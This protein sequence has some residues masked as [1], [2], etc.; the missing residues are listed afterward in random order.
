MYKKLAIIVILIAIV[1]GAV[2]L[3][4]KPQAAVPVKTLTVAKGDF[5]ISVSSATTS[6]VKS[7]REINISAQR[8]GKL[9]AFSLNEGD[10]VKKGQVVARLDSEEAEL[11]VQQAGASLRQAKARIGQIQ[12]E[13]TM[14]RESSMAQV[15]EA[16]A[17]LDEAASD[18]KR[19]Q[20]L[21]ERGMISRQEIDAAVGAEGGARG[22]YDNAIANRAQEQIKEDELTTARARLRELEATLGLT[23]LQVDYGTIHAPIN[24]VV[25]KKLVEQGEYVM[26]GAPLFRLTDPGNL[27]IEVAIDE[28]DAKYLKLGQA[29]KVR[30]D[31]FP[32]EH[33]TGRVTLV[34]PIVIGEKLQTRTFLVRVML[35][36][37][38]IKIVPGMSADVEII[39]QEV[40]GVL[41]IPTSSIVEKDQRKMVYVVAEGKAVLTPVTRGI[42]TWNATEITAGLTEG[43]KIVT[44]PEVLNLRDNVRVKEQ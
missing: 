22:R 37:R 38:R 10:L 8:N 13:I 33:F 7:E 31:A 5:T 14:A 25:S 41:S 30:M 42:T 35:D 16:K 18:L 4:K 28:F 11:Q 2:Y 6:T 20:I 9:I 43:R 1:A 29:A 26:T 32:G 17:A 23:S 3:I 19:K 44:N 36:D 24:G 39:A 21:F 12:A 27:Y 40:S 15:A 34:S